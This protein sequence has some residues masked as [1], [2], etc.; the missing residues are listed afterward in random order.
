VKRSIWI[1]GSVILL[2][3][4]LAGAAFLA[5]RLLSA[6]SQ[7]GEAAGGPRI[8]FGSGDGTVVEAQVERAKELPDSP[9]DAVGSFARRE[10]NSIFI[11]EIKGGFTI[12]VAEDGSVSTN[13]NG[14]EIEVVVTNETLIRVDV[15]HESFDDFPA[16]GT[17]EQKLKP[18]SVEEIDDYSFVQAW[19]DKRGDRVVAHVLVYTPPP[20]ISR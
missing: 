3:L 18:G 9:P 10:D 8:S 7:E 17:I 1:A 15:T 5:G 4:V 11:N 16:G 2:V 19:G 14:K 20:V 12:A 6:A 13:A